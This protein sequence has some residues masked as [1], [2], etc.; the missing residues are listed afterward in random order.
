MIDIIFLVGFFILLWP[1]MLFMKV[2]GL[3]GFYTRAIQ[4]EFIWVIFASLF[5][6]PF[7]VLF[8][9]WL[10]SHIVITWQ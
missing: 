5:S 8:L 4:E 10:S 2:L 6:W 1:G 9:Y 7:I 3:F